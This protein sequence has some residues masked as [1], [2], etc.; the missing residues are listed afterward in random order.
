MAAGELLAHSWL[1]ASQRQR[2]LWAENPSTK[3]KQ[4]SRPNQILTFVRIRPPERSSTKL[5]ERPTD[6]TPPEP[7]NSTAATTGTEVA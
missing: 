3:T 6:I 4:L 2:V 5:L 1:V 7:A